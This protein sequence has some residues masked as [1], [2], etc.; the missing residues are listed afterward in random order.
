MSPTSAD[1][2]PLTHAE[3]EAALKA[4]PGWSLAAGKLHR[5]YRFHDFKAAFG[6]MTSAA[7]AAEQMNH[8]PDWSNSWR[9]VTVDLVT[10]DAHAVTRKDVDLARA[11]EALAETLV[12][13]AKP[14]NP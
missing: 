13:P 5:S 7:L 8:H 11:F 14:A 4:L 3:I 1:R 12:A 2:R 9:D 10:H 6:W